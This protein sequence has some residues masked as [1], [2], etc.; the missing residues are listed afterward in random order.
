MI[1]MKK[2][3]ISIITLTITA[4]S[5][6]AQAQKLTDKDLETINK[7]LYEG[8]NITGL[9]IVGRFDIEIKHG[10]TTKA[11][12]T[13]S[14]YIFEDLEFSLNNQ[15]LKMSIVSSENK[16]I[17]KLFDKYKNGIVRKL[18]ITTPNFNHLVAVGMADVKF[19]S[20]FSCEDLNLE[21]TGMTDIDG[22]KFTVTGTAKVNSV[23]MSDITNAVI[24]GGKTATINSA[25]MSDI[26]I[27]IENTELVNINSAGLSDIEVELINAGEVKADC[28]GMSGIELDGNCETV[29]MKNS[30]MSN[31]SSNVETSKVQTH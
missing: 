22:A 28:S 6:N 11:E 3:I 31:I 2:I 24:K 4:L 1:I 10:K 8:E 18:V 17:N 25:G 16:K 14:R 13:T 23:G 21:A 20:A 9:K 15:I 12:L 30:G 26:E 29:S 27:Q 7:T 5:F 19:L